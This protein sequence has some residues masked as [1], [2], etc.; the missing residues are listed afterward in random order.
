MK[1]KTWL[2]IAA[3]GTSITSYACNHVGV[4]SRANRI[5][6][7]SATR[8]S[9]TAMTGNAAVLGT[10]TP[11]AVRTRNQVRRSSR[12]LQGVQA[13]ARAPV[14]LLPQRPPTVRPQ[15]VL[16]H[17]HRVLALRRG[18]ASAITDR[19]KRCTQTKK[20]GLKPAFLLRTVATARAAVPA[21]GGLQEKIAPWQRTL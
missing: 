20:A 6:K 4:P 5:R 2:S 9:P 10:I 3:Q 7:T 11:E 17:L 15:A 8:C 14:A 1:S 13:R 19:P 18:P 21:H 16:E 12:V